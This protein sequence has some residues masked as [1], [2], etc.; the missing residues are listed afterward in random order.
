MDVRR[1]FGISVLMSFIAF[2]MVTKLYIW[3]PLR[4]MRPEDALI[5]LVV[6][7]MFRFIGL[8]FL[9]VGVVTPSLQPAFAKPAA[10]G[11]LVA[12]ILAIAATLALSA[13]ASWAIAI[14][15]IFNIW[16]TA[17]LLHAIYQGQVRLRIGPGSL[18]AAFFIPT[19]I[20][21]PLLTTHWLIFRLLLSAR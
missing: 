18:G 7:H 14:V 11:D 13:H 10:Y 1:L 2:V 16:G 6:P 12:A 20:V 19:V 17:D 21:P 3:P 5:P 9:V 4:V 8:S 15:W